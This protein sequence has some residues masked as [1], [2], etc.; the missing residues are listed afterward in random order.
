MCLWC[1]L[2]CDM[3]S[4]VGYVALEDF[5]FRKIICIFGLLYENFNQFCSIQMY[6]IWIKFWMECSSKWFNC[7]VIIAY[8]IQY[9][10]SFQIFET[11]ILQKSQINKLRKCT[12]YFRS[13]IHCSNFCINF[14]RS[15]L[16]AVYLEVCTF[17]LS[18][19]KKKKIGSI[20]FIY[21]TYNEWQ[22]LIHFI[23]WNIYC[24]L[25]E[26]VTGCTMIVHP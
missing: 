2:A 7:D 24:F 16:R 17:P 4:L 12:F 26:I 18:V 5:N 3:A 23:L 22:L 10:L 9:I 19:K 6:H 25:D 14:I 15:F 1:T 13:N 20:S 11:H 8:F 21:C